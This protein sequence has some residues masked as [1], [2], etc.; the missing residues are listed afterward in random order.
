MRQLLQAATLSPPPPLPPQSSED[1]GVEGCVGYTA[2]VRAWLDNQGGRSRFIN[3]DIS[4]L[5]L[6]IS[7]VSYGLSPARTLC[8]PLLVQMA[9]QEAEKAAMPGVLTHIWGRHLLV[10]QTARDGF[11]SIVRT[12]AGPR[13]RARAKVLLERCSFVGDLKAQSVAALPLTG[14][15]KRRTKVDTPAPTYWDMRVHLPSNTYQRV[16]GAHSI[17]MHACIC[18]RLSTQ[19]GR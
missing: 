6:L 14:K 13:E 16:G 12:I 19:G 3:L 1:T 17:A 15:V 2:A 11:N 18:L 7:D 5:V 8:D 10:C 9:E 4:S